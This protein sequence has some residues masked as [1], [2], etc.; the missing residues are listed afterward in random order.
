MASY[1]WKQLKEIIANTQQRHRDYLLDEVFNEEEPKSKN[2]LFIDE[3]RDHLST[4]INRNEFVSK[5]YFVEPEL[6][7]LEKACDCKVHIE[8]KEDFDKT[9][10]VL[11]LSYVKDEDF[12]P[13]T[14]LSKEFIEKL[15]TKDEGKID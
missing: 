2:Q 13:E 11:Y 7:Y 10:K 12:T 5:V 6:F 14:I 1:K 3:V 9:M 8:K 4:C 15:N